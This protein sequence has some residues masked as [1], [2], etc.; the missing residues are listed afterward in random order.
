MNVRS[1]L[2]CHIMYAILVPVVL[3]ELLDAELVKVLRFVISLRID[4]HYDLSSILELQSIAL[5][6]MQ[7]SSGPQ[8]ACLAFVSWLECVEY[9]HE[10]YC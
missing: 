1:E 9:Y 10:A 7:V 2:P 4:S 6:A 8:F 5:V 3:Q